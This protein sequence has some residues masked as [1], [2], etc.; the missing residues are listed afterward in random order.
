M[1]ILSYLT[2]LLKTEKEV[3]IEELG[4]FFRVKI[5]G[6]YDVEN[7][8]FIP[9]KY[10]LNFKSEVQETSR[11]TNYISAKRDIS[12]ESAKHYIGLFKEDINRQL[13]VSNEADLDT[14]GALV[15][16]GNNLVLK[17]QGSLNLGFNF[18]G[19]P[20]ISTKG[21]VNDARSL[22]NG[23]TKTTANPTVFHEVNDNQEVFDEISE[24]QQI[25][26]PER[27]IE[28]ETPETLIKDDSDQNN[29]TPTERKE[30]EIQSE[31]E[32]ESHKSAISILPELNEHSVSTPTSVEKNL[33]DTI[34]PAAIGNNANT[35]SGSLLSDKP[36]GSIWH[37]DREK[38]VS[39]DHNSSENSPDEA[40]SS[41]S[42]WI[43]G[44]ILAAII[45]ATLAAVAYFARPDWFNKKPV[46]SVRTIAKKA[47]PAPV[48][49]AKVDTATAKDSSRV[50]NPVI[51]NDTAKAGVS[52]VGAP[53][54]PSNATTWEIIGASLTK[55]EVNWYLRDMKAR[56]YV[57]KP[58][59]ALPGKRIKM[60]I[61]TFNDKESAK[62]GR[63]LLIKKLKNKDLYI[64]ENK[65]TQKPK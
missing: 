24:A 48:P 17:E 45:L 7:H 19:L 46:S 4:T 42:A 1:D 6:R 9:P 33:Q 15:S 22:S 3:G 13:A 8:S 49:M 20:N 21:Q 34:L 44:F 61:A 50:V 57:V 40:S 38:P 43:K 56:G 32:V 18:Y 2:D 63:K 64:F 31:K 54:I 55:K 10:T 27:Q 25:K 36:T 35:G 58:M 37:F 30:I 11:L 28:I 53:N 51:A 47:V 60:S 12:T 65:N 52:A 5:P 41:T 62:E 16:V 59:P 29:S 39:G 23:E 26:T 14:L